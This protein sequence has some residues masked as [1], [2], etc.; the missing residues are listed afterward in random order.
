MFSMIIVTSFTT[1]AH[2]KIARA[3]DKNTP[4]G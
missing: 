4:P 3:K 1:R 2:E